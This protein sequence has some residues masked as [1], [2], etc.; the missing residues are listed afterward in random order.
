MLFLCY[1]D[2][3]KITKTKNHV[4]IDDVVYNL[5]KAVSEHDGRT[6]KGEVQ[7]LIEQRHNELMAECKRK[8]SKS[9]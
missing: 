3:M 5:L 9:Y 6:L 1:N 4:Y 8:S 7:Y 2:Y